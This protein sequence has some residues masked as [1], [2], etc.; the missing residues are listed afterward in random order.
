MS[1]R[2]QGIAVSY[3]QA[4][5][6]F[7]TAADQGLSQAQFNLGSLYAQGRGIAA[8]DIQAHFWM[9]LAIPHLTEQDRERA[10]ESLRFLEK[11][12]SKEQIIEAQRLSRAWKPKAS[13]SSGMAE[14]F[15]SPR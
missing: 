6:W 12:M 1:T 10:A 7:R 2:G 15:K 4:A 13:G 11:R 9:A 3:E 14:E 5:R 8:D